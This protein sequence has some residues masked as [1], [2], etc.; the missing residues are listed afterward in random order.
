MA[1]RRLGRAFFERPAD[2]VAPALLGAIVVSILGGVRTSGRIVEAEAYLGEHDPAS[3]GYRL[4]RHAGN[5]ALYGNPGD[6][7]VY[8]SYGIHWCANLVCGPRG[9]G[10]AVLLRALEPLEGQGLMRR[11][12]KGVAERL[13][14]NGPGKLCQALGITRALDGKAMASSAVILERA[15]NPPAIA[16]GI[17]IGITKAADWPLRF[18]EVGSPWLSRP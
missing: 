13:L 11:R 14:C 15:A 6:W 3:H 2:Q 16:T 1:V 17:R 7:Y 9:H 8:L 4:R 12:R 18:S 10:S 5:E